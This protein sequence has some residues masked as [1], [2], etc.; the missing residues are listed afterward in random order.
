MSMAVVTWLP[1][2]RVTMPAAL[3]TTSR[4]VMASRSMETLMTMTGSY[5]ILLQMPIVQHSL[6]VVRRRSRYLAVRW[7]SSLPRRRTSCLTVMS[8]VVV[9][10]RPPQNFLLALL[11]T[12]TS[13]VRPS[14]RAMSTKRM[15]LSVRNVLNL[16]PTRSI[17]PI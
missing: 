1:W 2:V 12:A 16:V 10:V 15:L 13:T 4:A 9:P 7:V 11:Q 8:S 3:M 14:S 6:A 17:I 5:G